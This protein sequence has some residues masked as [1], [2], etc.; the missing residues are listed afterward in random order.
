MR[1][2]HLRILQTRVPSHHAV[3]YIPNLCKRMSWHASRWVHLDACLSRRFG[4]GH[5][6]AQRYHPKATAYL[7]PDGFIWTPFCPDPDQA[8]FESTCTVQNHCRFAPNR[9]IRRPCCPDL[10][11]AVFE[12]RDT[13]QK[14]SQI[15]FQIASFRHLS[16]QILI[17]QVSSPH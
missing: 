3:A 7:F 11:E 16:V 15:C 2:L 9:L 5:F 4:S 14:P 13:M 10:D 12:F 6:R 17:R 8:I 1:I